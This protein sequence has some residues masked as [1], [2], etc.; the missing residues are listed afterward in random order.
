MT[1]L[2]WIGVALL[3]A[4]ILAS[5]VPFVPG[6][7]LAIVGLG[8]HWWATGEPSGLLLWGLL[9]IGLLALVFDWLGSAVAARLGGAS[10]SVAGG[11]AIVGVV[12]LFLAGP[13]GLLVGVAGTVFLSELRRGSDV[14]SSLR[15]AAIATVGVLASAAL[16][17][18]LTGAVLVVFL[19]FVGLPL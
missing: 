9:S 3:V 10:L 17:V 4:G 6:G 5:F 19:L 16:Q 2:A 14:R 11:A 1:L 8:L 13:F 7:L 12:G 15:A 18:V